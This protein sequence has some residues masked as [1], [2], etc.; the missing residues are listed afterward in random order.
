MFA[1]MIK[2]MKFFLKYHIPEMLRCSI[3]VVL[4]LSLASESLGELVNLDCVGP[5]PRG[6]R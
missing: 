3:S 2:F 4:K 5:T 6:L 1:E